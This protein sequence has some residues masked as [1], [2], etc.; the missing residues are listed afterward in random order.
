M[1]NATEKTLRKHYGEQLR[2]G[3]ARANAAVVQALYKA[4]IGSGRESVVAAIFWLKCR[5]G[6]ND[7]AR[8]VP[9]LGKKEIAQEMAKQPAGG[10]WGDDLNVV[11]FRPG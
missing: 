5:A 4:A 7:K 1:P 6:W 10:D 3:M 8:E 2:L 9:Q 11:P